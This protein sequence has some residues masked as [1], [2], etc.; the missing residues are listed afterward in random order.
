MLD[1]DRLK[2][3]VLER[4]AA[5][6]DNNMSTATIGQQFDFDPM[7]HDL[8]TAL[9]KMPTGWYKAIASEAAL[10]PTKDERGVK[11][12]VKWK[13]IDGPYKDR[14]VIFNY[15]MRNDSAQ[16]VEISQKQ[17][18]T[19][20]GCMGIW[21]KLSNTA[22]ILNI[23]IQV[24]L[25]DKSDSDYNDVAG[26]KTVDGNDAVK[27]GAGA[28]FAVP[29][30]APGQVPYAAPAAP[31]AAPPIDP[32]ASWQRSPDNAWKLNPATNA[33]EANTAPAP[34]PPP[35]PAAPPAPPAPAYAAAPAYAPP[36]QPGAPP[37][38]YPAQA[39]APPAAPVA[40]PP[41]V[42]TPGQAGAPAAPV[43]KP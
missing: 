38:Q 39:P 2:R 12:E 19:F 33:W 37:A 34:A 35:A 28:M 40:G 17:V 24:K 8:Q 4:L 16:A 1:F 21:R 18:A 15:N 11:L 5:Q 10:K 6:R 25:K 3:D 26:Y 14:T 31:P 41:A 23:P 13:I 30:Q 22:E 29:T 7:Q 32:T 9:D 43:W 36:Q 20:C 27:P 42:W